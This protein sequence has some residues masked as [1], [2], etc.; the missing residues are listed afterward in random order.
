MEAC[1]PGESWGRSGGDERYFLLVGGD[2]SGR[3]RWRVTGL[4][5]RPG[6]DGKCSASRDLYACIAHKQLG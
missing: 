5:K 4:G 6:R 2:V 1:G 3:S